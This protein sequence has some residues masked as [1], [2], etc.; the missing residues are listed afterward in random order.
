M[1]LERILDLWAV[2]SGNNGRKA[3]SRRQGRGWCYPLPGLH[4]GHQSG[5]QISPLLLPDM[6]RSD[7][8][9]IDMG[10]WDIQ[11]RQD[12]VIPDT[13]HNTLVLP[14]AEV[15]LPGELITATWGRFLSVLISRYRRYD[16]SS[17]LCCLGVPGPPELLK[18]LITMVMVF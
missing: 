15:I 7:A 4:S 12:R 2:W 9:D 18:V 11:P 8:L 5:S 17:D 1:T 6:K 10:Q 13:I 14:F 16:S 3:W